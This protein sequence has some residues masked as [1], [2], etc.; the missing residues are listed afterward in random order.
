MLT[1]SRNHRITDRLKT[2]FCMGKTMF[3]F[4]PGW[5]PNMFRFA[6]VH[7]S[8][9]QWDFVHYGAPQCEE[10]RYPRIASAFRFTCYRP[11]V[12]QYV[13]IRNVDDTDPGYNYGYMF[14]LTIQEIK[15]IGKRTLL[16]RIYLSIYLS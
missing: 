12:G 8:K 5:F 4:L 14:P 1:E 11:T 3:T 6:S 10:R 7:I 9:L 15:V 13:T 16:N 2:T